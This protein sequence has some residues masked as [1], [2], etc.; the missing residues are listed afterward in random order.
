MSNELRLL[1][2]IERVSRRYRRLVLWGGLSACWLVLALVAGALLA[3]S[4]GRG[5]AVPGAALILLIVLPLGALL[6]LMS[7]WRRM[8]SPLWVAHRIERRFPE[9]DTRLLAALEQTP[10]RGGEPLGFLL[11]GPRRRGRKNG[12]GASRS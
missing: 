6:L 1:E 2:E 10:K 4:R 7:A 3:W 8:K 5:Y 12:C 9:L 11:T